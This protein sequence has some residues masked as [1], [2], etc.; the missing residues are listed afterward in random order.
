MEHDWHHLIETPRFPVPGAAEFENNVESIAWPM[1]GNIL[2]GWGERGRDARNVLVLPADQR[3]AVNLSDCRRE[4]TFLTF[5]KV[6]VDID[7]QFRREW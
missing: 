6:E 4:V 7:S 3:Y 2:D 5:P 1:G